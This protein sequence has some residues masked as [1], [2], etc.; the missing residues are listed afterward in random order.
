MRD[1][2]EAVFPLLELA[3]NVELA[4]EDSGKKQKEY[5]YKVEWLKKLKLSIKNEEAHN[6][7]ALS[8]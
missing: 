7:P 5:L 2:S 4:I 8:E 1:S 3:K 6:L